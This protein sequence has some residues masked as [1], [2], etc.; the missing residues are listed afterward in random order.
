MVKIRHTFVKIAQ[1]T[2]VYI[3]MAANLNSWFPTPEKYMFW[4]KYILR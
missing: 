1:I 2:A 3:Y 4:V